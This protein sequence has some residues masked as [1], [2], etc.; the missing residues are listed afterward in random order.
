MLTTEYPFLPPRATFKTKLFHPNVNGGFI[1][2]EVYHRTSWIG[3]SQELR[4]VL[5]LEMVCIDLLREPDKFIEHPTN[6]LSI[7]FQEDRKMFNKTACEWTKKYASK[8]GK[9]WQTKIT[10]LKQHFPED[11]FL[12][13][14]QDP[15]S[16]ISWLP[17]DVILVI[18]EKS[19]S[20]ESG[21]CHK[22]FNCNPCYLPVCANCKNRFCENC[23]AKGSHESCQTN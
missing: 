1:G 20:W 15:T 12:N 2:K 4:V 7:L 10:R 13:L 8:P 22:C 6:D 5:F 3:W 18:L 9:A 21:T 17:R 14:Q 11:E 23:I 19:R 16:F